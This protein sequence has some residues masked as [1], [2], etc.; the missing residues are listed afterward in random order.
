MPL[1]FL[2]IVAIKYA[3]DAQPVPVGT[4]FRQVAVTSQ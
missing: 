3:A 2:F 4:S 1:A